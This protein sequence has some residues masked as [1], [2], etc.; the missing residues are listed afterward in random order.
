MSMA[1][2]SG[3]ARHASWRTACRRRRRA[4]AARSSRDQQP[5]SSFPQSRPRII[6]SMPRLD[7]S[8][9]SQRPPSQAPPRPPPGTS[10]RTASS[11]AS[12]TS[13]LRRP[14][15]FRPGPAGPA[16]VTAAGI[17]HA[18]EAEE[19]VVQLHQPLPAVHPARHAGDG[20]AAGHH[21]RRGGA[22]HRRLER[23]IRAVPRPS[24]LAPLPSPAPCSAT[25]P[26]TC[27]PA[28][29]SSCSASPSGSARP[30]ALRTSS[31][32][33]D[34]CWCSRSASPGPGP[35]SACSCAPRR[36]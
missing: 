18:E 3:A 2:G 23:D 5:G 21:V 20:R 34:S 32:G 24:H 33:S 28:G 15:P 9:M 27:W 14:R 1:A 10:S 30:A 16:V 6:S 11:T 26:V 22:E 7:C 13:H 29:W 36:R 19:A 12:G 35:P 8:S 17:V 31:P 25:S 4:G